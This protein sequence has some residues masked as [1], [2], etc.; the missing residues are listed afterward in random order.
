MPVYYKENVFLTIVL[1]PGAREVFTFRICRW[2]INWPALSN[3]YNS[4]I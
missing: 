1:G 3:Q 2:C 4:P